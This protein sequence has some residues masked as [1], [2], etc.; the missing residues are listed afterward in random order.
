MRVWEKKMISEGNF[1][2]IRKGT[3][4]VRKKN[5]PTSPA[6]GKS[7]EE[8]APKSTLSNSFAAKSAEEI[9][10]PKSEQVIFKATENCRN[11]LSRTET[12]KPGSEQLQVDQDQ[13]QSRETDTPKDF[14]EVT[15][16]PQPDAASSF[17]FK[18]KKFFKI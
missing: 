6:G 15:D 17:A 8:G 14:K 2:V 5:K 3:L 16:S 13:K 4:Q 10:M 1:D 7:K 12:P 11:S 9:D 18:F